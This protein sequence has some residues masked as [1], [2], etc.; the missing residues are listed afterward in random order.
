MRYVHVVGKIQV[1]ILLKRESPYTCQGAVDLDAVQDS[2]ERA[3]L[4][5]QIQEFGQTPK[6]LFSTPHPSRARGATTTTY[7]HHYYYYYY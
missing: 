3:A 6:Q 5:M 1:R 7:Y 4:E 2:R